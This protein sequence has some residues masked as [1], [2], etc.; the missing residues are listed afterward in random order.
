MTSE[1]NEARDLAKERTEWAEDRTL[2]ASERTFSSWMGTGLG[3]LGLAVGMQAVFGA[4]EPT[5]IAKVA[6]TI[7]VIVA[8]YMFLTA[9]SNA[10]NTLNRLN[11]NSAEP[12]SG[13]KL[14]II[15]YLMSLGGIGV[16][17]ILWLI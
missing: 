8:L 13:N 9:L 11:A 3:S 1:N 17:V 10:K 15:A 16:G 2:L 6:A 4:M 5:W 12:V 7:F 14:A